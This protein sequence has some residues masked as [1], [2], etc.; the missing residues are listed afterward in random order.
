MSDKVVSK[1]IGFYDVMKEKFVIVDNDVVE[2]ENLG[3]AMFQ[4]YVTSLDFYSGDHYCQAVS[5]D[6]PDGICF[7]QI[8]HWSYHEEMLVPFVWPEAKIRLKVWSNEERIVGNPLDEV[9]ENTGQKLEEIVL[10][11][12][13]IIDRLHN[14]KLK[15]PKLW[16]H[17]TQL[18]DYPSGSEAEGIAQYI[19]YGE[20]MWG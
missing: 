18:N 8:K 17:L 4:S 20:W 19:A 1:P 6:L 15:R 9:C 2:L 10:D 11:K 16:E 14:L 5:Y 3:Q 7:E 13:T 12:K